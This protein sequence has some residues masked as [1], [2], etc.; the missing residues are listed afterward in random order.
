MRL[1]DRT[2]IWLLSCIVFTGCTIEVYAPRRPPPPPPRE[3]HPG[4]ELSSATI[5][6]IDAT[7]SLLMPQD[8]V[9]VLLRIAER[10]SL[11][12]TEQ[13]YL[14]SFGLRHLT[15]PQ[16]QESLL[17]RLIENPS[18]CEEAKVYILENLEKLTFPQHRTRVLQ[19]INTRE[20]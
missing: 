8:R 18:F 14:V 15:F 19:A 2:G 20:S 4:P 10:D 7:E 11:T 12:P 16:H 3:E 5:A 17:V 13:V 9:E 1:T 6:E